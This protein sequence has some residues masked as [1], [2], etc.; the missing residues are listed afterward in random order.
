MLSRISVGRGQDWF[1]CRNTRLVRFG[2][3]RA[4]GGKGGTD[5]RLLGGIVE[6]NLLKQRP[7][8]CGANECACIKA[9]HYVQTT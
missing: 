8:R 9:T 5:D 3:F 7:R 1:G 2:S 4:W 6:V